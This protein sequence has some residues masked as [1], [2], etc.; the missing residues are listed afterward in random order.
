EGR[1][2]ELIPPYAGCSMQTGGNQLGISGTCPFCGKPYGGTTMDLEN[3]FTDPFRARTGCCGATVY[4]READMP[5]DYPARPN[6]TERIPH[7]DG[8][9]MEY[10]FFVPPGK[11]NAGPELGS[12]R[13]HWFCSA[14][15]VWWA[16]QRYLQASEADQTAFGAL[17][18]AVVFSNDAKAARALAIIYDR[19]ADVYPGYPLVD[20]SGTPNGLARGVDGTR[21]L[22]SEEYRAT[23]TP[24]DARPAWL[25]IPPYYNLGKM[26][27]A[28]SWQEGVMLCL[29]NLAGIFDLIRDRPEVLAY[30][31]ERYG[32]ET[33]WET[34]VRKGV[35]DELCFLGLVSPP[36]H[37]GNTSYAWI[38]GA[39][40]LG[41]V[42]Q[43]P[44]FLR[45]AVCLVEQDVANHYF[46]DGLS[47]QGAFNYAGM[48]RH[49]VNT[50]VLLRDA[51]GLDLVERHP[52]LPVIEARSDSF[53]TTL[54]GVE[55]MHSDEH[56]FF[57]GGA[58]TPWKPRPA[59]PPDY[60][61]HEVSQCDPEYGLACLR[62]GAPGYRLESIM[63]FQTAI[64]HTHA[65][66][67]NLQVFYEGINLMP[68]IG[69][70]CVAADVTRPPWSEF[71]YPFEKIPYPEGADFWGAWYYTY[72][73]YP[74]VHCTAMV[75]GEHTD[76]QRIGPVTF[77]RFSGDGTFGSPDY[78]AQF[79]QVNGTGLFNLR[80]KPV[81]AF[82]RQLT[83]VTTA[84]GR[85]L[86]LDVFRLRGGRRHDLLWH[87][88]STGP[89][90]VLETSLGKPTP[91]E[92][93]MNDLWI[94]VAS[95]RVK[96]SEAG[97]GAALIGRL[98]RWTFPPQ[99]W[100]TTFR[101]EPNVYNPVTEGGRRLYQPWIEALHPVRLRLWGRATGSP[102]D[103]Q[104]LVAGRG[105]WPSK[106]REVTPDGKE[107]S[108]LVALK[109]ALHVVDVSRRVATG[110]LSTAFAHVLEPFNPDQIPVVDN[111]TM[112][113]TREPN[114]GGPCMGI[115]MRI[116]LAGS[117]VLCAASTL[118]GGHVEADGVVL[119]G[120][121]G[122]AEPGAHRLTLFDG[123]RFSA[124]GLGVEL[125]EGW[126][127]E[128]AGVVGDLTG[129]AGES[130]L[131]VAAPR[132][133]PTD[134]TLVGRMV[135]VEH[136]IG[137][138][139]TSGYTIARVSAWSGNLYR[140][141]LRNRPSFLVNRFRVAEVY[142]DDPARFKA[143]YW[144]LKGDSEKGQ[145]DGRL[146]R[147]LRR[148]FESAMTLP[149]GQDAW[150]HAH[151]RLDRTPPTPLAVGEPF[152]IYQIQPGDRVR[153]PSRFAC[154]GERTPDGLKLDMVTTGP[155]V[156]TVPGD[157]RRAYLSL[158]FTQAPLT[159]LR[160]TKGST[161]FR[162]R[163][164]D[165]T[166]G[167]ASVLLRR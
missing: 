5:A 42:T 53:V 41:L 145:Y 58:G 155:A 122:V 35:L 120:R 154:Q 19:L 62:A 138:E 3:V 79:L 87:A 2:A 22:T 77:R 23:P 75:D 1:W 156:L 91:V 113:A 65:A 102:A 164:E 38:V 150:H 82:D 85:P 56:A 46:G 69:Y 88:P 137:P 127:L 105:P 20:N 57:F 51:L 31:R 76:S 66:R 21:Y 72:T 52:L 119:D 34:R 115:G 108:M 55:S 153:I 37:G 18:A 11:E 27:R 158:G 131:L 89:D 116:A 50:A 95:N 54:Y 147:F 14:A 124:D 4:E 104:E 94:P 8:T 78:N 129:H 126:D 112:L 10:R 63:D 43:K 143:D 160:A 90:E 26:I 6:H 142:P 101:I 84:G 162:I 125:A 60:A 64:A 29:G 132:P 99:G 24:S 117:G 68:D 13:R 100:N 165:T 47:C 81:A 93:S 74:E 103:Q 148:G 141:D 30:S 166:D 83:A 140:L 48:L 49:S 92:G 12:E 7:L 118:D 59:I 25:R 15:E 44:W 133:L 16:R 121:L 80:A 96:Q 149:P 67:L 33:A 36:G 61:A 70:A 114:G 39:L 111:V 136:R 73:G 106:I 139:H 134:G 128:L 109:D 71:R 130:A 45:T 146:V 86:L 151:I 159:G 107:V 135:T 28:S 98:N 167:H 157:Y 110:E 152:V 17:A 32:D 161:E 163:L 144:L 123:T 97:T 40:R 9:T